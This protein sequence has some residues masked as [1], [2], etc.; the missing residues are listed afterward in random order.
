MNK[1]S[2]ATMLDHLQNYF[3]YSI[4]AEDFLSLTPKKAK[5]LYRRGR[6]L[7]RRYAKA[8][9]AYFDFAPVVKSE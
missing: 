2:L 8:K 7:Y 1:I 9:R 3:H 5:R 4:S 6:K